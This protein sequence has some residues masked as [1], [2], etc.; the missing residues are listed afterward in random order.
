[1]LDQEFGYVHLGRVIEDVMQ[2]PFQTYVDKTCS[3]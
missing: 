3:S 2:E 1:M